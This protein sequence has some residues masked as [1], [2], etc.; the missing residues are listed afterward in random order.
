MKREGVVIGAFGTKGLADT[1]VNK[2]MRALQVTGAPDASADAG[3]LSTVVVGNALAAAQASELNQ[4][5]SQ[6]V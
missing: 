3:D 6:D 5:F 2:A 1:L 4:W